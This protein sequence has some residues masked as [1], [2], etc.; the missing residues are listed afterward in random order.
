MLVLLFFFFL[1]KPHLARGLGSS[2]LL[3]KN[4]ST[5]PSCASFTDSLLEISPGGFWEVII[6]AMGQARFPGGSSGSGR[7][8]SSP[9]DLCRGHADAAH[10]KLRKCTVSF[11]QQTVNG[12]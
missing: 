4:A 9:A 7:F 8:L 10:A 6:W 11:R 12:Q 5:F 3:H 1:S 2:L